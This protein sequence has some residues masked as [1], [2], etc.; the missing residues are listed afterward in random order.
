VATGTITITAVPGETYSFDGSAYSAT[1]IYS[2]LAAGSSHTVTAQNVAGC[3]SAISSITLNALPAIP[4]APVLTA[5]QPTCSV[6]TGTMT[7]TAVAGETYS[8]NGSAY[9]GILIYSGLAASSSHTVTAQNAAGCVSAISNITLGALPAIPS[10]PVLTPTQP[11]CS[12]ATG[13]ITITAVAGETYSFN[14]S[15]YSATLIYTGLA[16]GSSHTVTAQNVAGCISAISS[17]MLNAL[18]AIPSAPVLT[19]TQPTCSLAT[20]TITITAVA[21]ETYSFDG[22]AYSGILI[23]S[24]LAASSSHTVTAQNAVGCIS[25]ISSITLASPVGAP[26]VPLINITQ[27]TC[28]VTTGTITI[29]GVSG[30]SYSLDNGSFTTV[31]TYGGLAAGSSHTITAQNAVGCVAV[32]SITLNVQPIAPAAPILLPTQ[33]TC[34]VSTGS[35]TITAVAGETYSLDGA[36]FSGTLVYSGLAAGSSHTVTAQNPAGCISAPSNITINSQPATPMPPIL[37]STEPSCSVATG[38]VTITAI[39][40]MLYSFDGGAYTTTLVYN[41]LAAGSSHSVTALN[42]AGCIS[43][44]STITLSIPAAAP[45]APIL[46]TAQPSCTAAT[47]GITITAIA[48]LTYSFDGG[49]Y[50]TTLIYNGIPAG[51]THTVTAQNASG[52]ISPIATVTVNAQPPSPLGPIITTTQ[53]TCATATGTVTIIGE[54]GEIYSFDGG[55]YS[56]MLIY[57]G[58]AAGATHI[59]TAQ[60]ADGC[61]S[62]PSTITLNNQPATPAAPIVVAIQPTCIVPTG[63][64]NITAL[65]GITYSFDG[66]AFSSILTYNGLSAGSSHTVTAQNLAGCISASAII[67]INIQPTTPAAPVLTATQPVCTM[68]TGTL[69]ITGVPGITYSF[70]G[71]VYSAT[72]VYS[73]LAGGSTHSVT[74]QNAAGCISAVASITFNVSPST[75]APAIVTVAQ[76]TCTETTGTITITAV[77]GAN[78]SF[79]GGAYSSTLVFGGLAAGSSHTVIVRNSLGCTSNVT[80]ANINAQPLTPIAATSPSSQ[81][82][83]SNNST[84]IALSAI[85]GTIFS[86]TVVQQN[87]SGATAGIGNNIAQTLLATGNVAGQAVYT[88]TPT[89]NGCTGL[90]ITVTVTVNPLPAIIAAP[91]AQTICSGEAASIVLSAVDTNTTFNWT[92]IQ[93]GVTGALPGGGNTVSQTLTTTSN[94]FGTATYTITPIKNGC[95]GAPVQ[96]TVTVNPKPQLNVPATV[97]F[98]DGDV[99]NINLTANIPGTTFS[100]TVSQNNAIGGNNGVGT[101]I[102]EQLSLTGSNSGTVIYTVTPTANGCIGNAITITVQVNPLPT[103]TLIDGTV[104][105]I[106]SSGNTVK[107]YTLNTRLSNSVYDFEWFLDGN[108]INGIVDNSYEAELPGNYSVIATNSLTGCVSAAVF[109]T[110]TAAFV[111]DGIIA[112]VSQ[113][114]TENSTIVISIP[115]GTGPF[116]YQLDNGAPQIS[117]TFTT[118]SSGVHKVSV[119]DAYGCT[120]LQTEVR[121]INYPKYFTP[122]GDGY[123]DT[124][125]IFDLADQDGS[126]IFIFDRYGKMVKEIS[127]KSRGWDG[128]YNGSELP[129]TD[130]WFSVDYMEANTP[131]NFKA[132]FSLKR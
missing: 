69:T 29:I 118:L 73:G 117:N 50:N 63:S 82:I 51:S 129:G 38:T 60:N 54:V 65:P 95:F 123:N 14:G 57:S 114:F 16:G 20:G 2:G 84:S 87:V 131:K 59:I 61:I 111:G 71:G 11:T 98:C 41:G 88:I 44:A 10:A 124:W 1:L 92:V 48:G 130:Y 23:Y 110:V 85:P 49:A 100:W 43:A 83:C 47:G 40:G 125:N 55:S 34:I 68:P 21:G 127:P 108:P 99:T 101:I 24:G 80:T 67:T 36:P 33:P 74:A 7:I 122:N 9:S 31:L 128:T 28:T 42:T 102:S 35:I 58:L 22:S 79:D 64:I 81:T 13:T 19:A 66:G 120:D 37:T 132:H 91:T 104:C 75:P 27:P 94:T 12:L 18:P 62:A 6:A 8:F 3:I 121:I 5:T 126:R 39:S 97:S 109:A 76:P 103:P 89:A 112:V 105:V 78:F 56:A 96:V 4:T 113:A 45:A 93:T 46:T 77:P 26:A 30:I 116:L 70:D 72:L 90:P 106:Q 52:C 107:N 25:L 17:I 32:S 86:W 53:A 119:T 15:A 115:I